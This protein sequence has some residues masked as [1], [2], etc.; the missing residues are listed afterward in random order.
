[1]YGDTMPPATIRH[2][3]VFIHSGREF[4]PILTAFGLLRQIF[5]QVLNINFQGNP[6][7]GNCAFI[8]G[9]AD[10][11]PASQPTRQTDRESDF[12]KVSEIF[13]AEPGY[14]DNDFATPCIQ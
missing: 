11:R 8:C 12:A 13:T 14:K 4:C 5:I 2:T 3:E 9:D 7:R 10:G 6:S 1:M